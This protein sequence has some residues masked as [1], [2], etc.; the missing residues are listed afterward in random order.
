MKT[1]HL[2]SRVVKWH[3]IYGSFLDPYIKGG[4]IYFVPLDL[5]SRE[6][7]VSCMYCKE[8]VH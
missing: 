1:K 8:G 3:P 7:S 5:N 6:L 4:G 2:P